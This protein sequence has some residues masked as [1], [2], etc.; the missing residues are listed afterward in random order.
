MRPY[1][2]D[3]PASGRLAVMPRPEGGSSLAA[4][5]QRLRGKGVDML[6]CAL[7]PVERDLLGLDAEPEEARQAGLSFVE[8]PIADFSVPDVDALRTL[9]KQ[10]AKDIRKGNYVV[11]H[12]RG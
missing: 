3:F 4:D 2:I 8:F 12:C 10:L 5:L 6:V 1:L 7:T 11:V 9:A